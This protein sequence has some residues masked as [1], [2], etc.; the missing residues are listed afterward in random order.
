[1]G[2]KITKDKYYSTVVKELSDEQRGILYNDNFALSLNFPYE[3][4]IFAAREECGSFEKAIK[5]MQSGIEKSKKCGAAYSMLATKSWLCCNL[6]NL[7]GFRAAITL[8]V[9]VFGDFAGRVLHK[10]IMENK[11][12]F[13]VPIQSKLDPKKREVTLFTAC[14]L[15]KKATEHIRSLTELAKQ[16]VDLIRDHVRKDNDINTDSFEAN[17]FFSHFKKISEKHGAKDGKLTG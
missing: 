16:V 7:G 8:K 14:R 10:F 17:M 4:F 1:M 6:E 13:S 2:L 5:R 11:N 12:N 3:Q 9:Y 15:G